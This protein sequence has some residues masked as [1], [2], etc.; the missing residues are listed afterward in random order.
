MSIS[1]RVAAA[2]RVLKQETGTDKSETELAGLL[3]KIQITSAGT[4]VINKDDIDDNSP[5]EINPNGAEGGF[6]FNGIAGIGTFVSSVE[7]LEAEL[8]SAT[9]PISEVI[10]HW[11][12]TFTN[13]NLDVNDILRI[14]NSLPY[15]Y[16]IKRNGSLQRGIPINYPGSHGDLLNHNTYSIGIAFVGGLNYPTETDRV[17]ETSSAGSITRSQ[18]NTFYQFMRVFYNQYPG[19]QLLGH[20]DFD[21][22]Q[23]DP[24]FDCRDYA[25]SCF[26]KYSLFVDPLSEP[27]KSPEEIV[28]AQS[29]STGSLTLEK[30]PEVLDKKI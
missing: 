23:E 14:S 10:L 16:I 7:E 21:I 27:A 18:Y 26:N 22:T 25:F 19:G 8:T 20:R 13:A 2:A 3:D 15:N 9:R 29:S 4:V 11:T 12:E 24:G 17:E 30:D 6:E 5:A 28:A 1:P